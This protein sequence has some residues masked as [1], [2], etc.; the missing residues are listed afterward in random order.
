M[1]KELK[2]SYFRGIKVA[3]FMTVLLVGA[4]L[5]LAWTSPAG[6]ALPTAGNTLAPIN[7]SSS[8]QA[9]SGSLGIGKNTAP[10]V[11]AQLDVNGILSTNSSAIFGTVYVIGGVVMAGV[12]PTLPVESNVRFRSGPL[13]SFQGIILETRTNDPIDP[14]EGRIWV[15]TD[16]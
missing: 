4:D 14:E 13:K 11:G 3:V 5:V 7:I 16:L 8:N 1:I 6:N 9:K 10:T 2:N 12:S 15:R